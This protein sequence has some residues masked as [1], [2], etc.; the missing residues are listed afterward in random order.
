MFIFSLSTLVVFCSSALNSNVKLIEGNTMLQSLF[1]G[2]VH[3]LFRQIIALIAC[4]V[5]FSLDC[6]AKD[7]SYESLTLV[8][9]LPTGAASSLT[10]LLL[11]PSPTRTICAYVTNRAGKNLF[12]QGHAKMISFSFRP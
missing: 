4:K 3:F 8:L 1:C 12:A 5:N 7:F 10:W 9:T 2:I 11:F 6:G